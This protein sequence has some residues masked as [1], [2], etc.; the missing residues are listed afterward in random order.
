MQISA[1]VSLCQC[2]CSGCAAGEVEAA[3]AEASPGQEQLRKAVHFEGLSV[4]LRQ[5]PASPKTNVQAGPRHCPVKAIHVTSNS[6]LLKT[7]PYSAWVSKHGPV[8]YVSVAAAL[9]VSWRAV[10]RQA[11]VYATV[12]QLHFGI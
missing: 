9:V 3:D 7:G 4:E 10:C 12:H 11:A 5:L 8:T 2:P 6:G 1:A